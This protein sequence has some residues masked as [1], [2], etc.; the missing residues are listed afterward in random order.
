MSTTKRAKDL[1][2]DFVGTGE[3][4]EVATSLNASNARLNNIQGLG[5]VDV[6]LRDDAIVIKGNGSK[7]GGVYTAAILPFE[8]RAK[9]GLNFEIG[10]GY[11]T[12]AWASGP[13][14]QQPQY[15]SQDMDQTAEYTATAN[16]LNYVF[17]QCDL[18]PYKGSYSYYWTYQIDSAEIVISTTW[19][20][21][22]DDNL[23]TGTTGHTYLYLGYVW[24]QGNSIYSIN[25]PLRSSA[26]YAYHSP[27][28][29]HTWSF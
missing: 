2:E 7:G 22:E 17:V 28:Q 4:A 5:T 27:W 21:V 15:N 26:K 19:N 14:S 6:L 10:T 12:S 20:P 23:P 25:S 29:G 11:I 24:T 1:P 8:M 9:S 16:S 3:L 13:D 18:T